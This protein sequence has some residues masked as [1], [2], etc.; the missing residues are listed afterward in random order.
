MVITR[1]GPVS[2]GKIAL[3]LY[4]AIGLL[5]GAVVS[6][7]SMAGGFASQSMDGMGIG[8][9]IGVASIIVFPL[10]YGGFGFISAVVGAWIY[11]I[12]AGIVGGVEIDTR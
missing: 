3:V 10:L 2:C 6:L 4:A 11:N 7:A 1:I 8:A 9:T 5:V 12:T